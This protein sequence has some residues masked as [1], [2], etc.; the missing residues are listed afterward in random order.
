M[1]GRIE[2]GAAGAQD[3]GR[4]LWFKE[5]EQPEECDALYDRMI[6]DGALSADDIWARVHMALEAGKFSAAKSTLRRLPGFDAASVRYLDRVYENPQRVL[7]KRTFTNKTRLGRELNLYAV[8]RVSRTQP[9]MAF[10]YWDAMKADFSRQEQQALWARMAL[11]ASRRHSPLALEW[12]RNAGNTPLSD[13][14]V[15]WKARAALRLQNWKAL[16]EVIASMPAQMQ[17]EDAWRYW[18]AR[19]LKAQGQGVAA[20]NLLLPLAR[21][22]NFY[23]LLAEEELGESIG[24]PPTTYK[25]SDAEVRAIEGLPGIRR[26]LELYRLDMRWDGLREW[27]Q[28]TQ[29]FDDK[30]LLAAAELAFQQE[31]YDIAINTAEKTRLTHDFALRYPTPY[32]DKLETYARENGLDEAWVY[33]LIRQESRFIDRARSRVGA[34]GLMQVMPRTAK[35][36]AKRLGIQGYRHDMI[37]K[38]DTNIQFGTHYLRY[39]MDQADGQSVI[40]TAAYN[41]GP[42]RARRWRPTQP[43]EGAIYAETIPFSETRDYVK[44]VMGNAHFYT[45]R[46]GLRMQSL[47]QRLGLVSTQAE[48]EGDAAE[49]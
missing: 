3:D 32:R 34:S 21:E 17:E 49:E 29:A 35:W 6:G 13:E 45:H 15:A 2:Q 43:I 18:K 24:V 28:A 48:P 36:I 11:H 41:A 42:S 47:K 37:Y 10:D 16:I 9:E 12:Y 26:A 44:K 27:K 19:A 40:A 8:E 14:Q 39:T 31:L 38:L 20:N 25:A 7:K 1:S 5:P 46:L 23:G 22:L 30:R 33:G 4:A